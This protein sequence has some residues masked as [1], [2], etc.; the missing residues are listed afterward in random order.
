MTHTRDT[1]SIISSRKGYKFLRT[2]PNKNQ[3]PS[4]CAVPLGMNFYDHVLVKRQ[5]IGP[6]LDPAGA[7][8]LRVIH[9]RRKEG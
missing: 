6:G 4:F 3:E 5:E 9:R 1:V 7:V 8:R 2:S